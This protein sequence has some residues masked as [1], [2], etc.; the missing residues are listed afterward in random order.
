VA[1]HLQ[2]PPIEPLSERAFD[3]VEAGVFERLDRADLV[4]LVQAPP[5]F[6]AIS[7]AAV[8]LA[9]SVFVFVRVTFPQLFSPALEALTESTAPLPAESRADHA[10]PGEEERV[11]LV[12]DRSGPPG[13]R[14]AEA[15][16]PEPPLVDGPRIVTTT[17]PARMSL[18][19]S[20][21]V[22]D[23]ESDVRL[24]GSDEAG[25]RVALTHGHVLCE[26]A[27]RLGRPDFVVQ[28]G[29]VLVRVVG[30]RFEVGRSVTRF[31]ST[32]LLS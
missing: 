18:G 14:A 17:S 6:A 12:A 26:V 8:A 20:S 4:P 29:E 16:A 27:P 28:A 5:R 19:E 11:G 9:L 32:S 3:R 25:W 13:S 21:L 24:T 10:S 15:N 22:I 31:L 1:P 2:P 30:T 23:N 7:L